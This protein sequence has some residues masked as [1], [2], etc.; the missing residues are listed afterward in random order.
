MANVKMRAMK[1]RVKLRILYLSAIVMNPFELCRYFRNTTWCSFS[2]SLK[3]RQQIVEK[4]LMKRL[5]TLDLV[6]LIVI[7]N[8][9]AIVTKSESGENDKKPWNKI[10]ALFFT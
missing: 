3:L 5:R 4:Y 7:L 2:S 10:Y 8:N 6:G 9:F 1:K